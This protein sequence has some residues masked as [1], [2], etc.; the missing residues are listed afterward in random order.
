[1]FINGGMLKTDESAFFR[2]S[3]AIFYKH[4]LGWLLSYSHTSPDVSPDEPRTATPDRP[5]VVRDILL[6]FGVSVTL[7][8]TSHGLATD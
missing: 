6:F 3:F 1:M 8:R 2:M 5:G 7:P 4:A